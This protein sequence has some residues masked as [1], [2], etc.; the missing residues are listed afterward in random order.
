MPVRD[1]APLSW[2]LALKP[3]GRGQ[4]DSVRVVATMS[5]KVLVKRAARAW[6]IG[7]SLMAKKR[8]EAKGREVAGF[9]GSPTG[10][11]TSI[12]DAFFPFFPL[13]G[14]PA[15]AAAQLLS[16]FF[17]FSFFIYIMYSLLRYKNSHAAL[18]M[19]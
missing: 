13:G 5:G 1:T 12:A 7:V 18:A 17:F 2:T 3:W 9:D 15:P 10:L 8:R 6:G 19:A 14:R 4:L 11:T 16:G